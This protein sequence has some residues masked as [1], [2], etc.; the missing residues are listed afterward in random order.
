MRVILIGFMGVGKTSVGKKLAKKLNFDFID[1]DYEIEILANKTIPDIFEQDGE[2]HFRKLES[3]ILEKFIKKEDVVISTGG[4]IITTK[5]NYNI[6]KNEENVIFL[7]ASVETIISHLQNERNKRPLLK[8]SENLNKKIE[9]MIGSIKWRC[10]VYILKHQERALRPRMI[11]WR[12]IALRLY[13]RC[14]VYINI[15]R[16]TII[17][18]IINSSL[19]TIN[20]IVNN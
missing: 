5:E 1:T 16:S 7:D 6:L 15:M 2:K 4:G 18:S 8:E 11:K 14:C 20:N 10:C 19:N 17:I 9:D 13:C 3:N 12:N